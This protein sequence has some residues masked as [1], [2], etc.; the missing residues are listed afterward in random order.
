MPG[1]DFEA[2]ADLAAWKVAKGTA[3][4][5]D[6]WAAFGNS[7]LKLRLAAG[8][9]AD[10]APPPG[11]KFVLPTGYGRL[12]CVLLLRDRINPHVIRAGQYNVMSGFGIR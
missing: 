3:E 8:G 12:E 2:K 5:T 10:F 4:L 11:A 6:E 1:G 9:A 7:A